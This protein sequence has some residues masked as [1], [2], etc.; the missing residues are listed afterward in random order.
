MTS[1]SDNMFG[2]NFRRAANDRSGTFC[3]QL[4]AAIRQVDQVTK[5]CFTAHVPT[6]PIDMT[7]PVPFRE[8]ARTVHGRAPRSSAWGV[9]REGGAPRREE[10]GAWCL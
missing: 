5:W 10:G 9:R 3:R 6:S 2:M 4:K 7:L 8:I 1:A